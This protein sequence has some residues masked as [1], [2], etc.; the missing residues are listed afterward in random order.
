MCLP[1]GLLEA[2]CVEKQVLSRFSWIGKKDI[3]LLI[4]QK[5]IYNGGKW[6]VNNISSFLNSV[7]CDCGTIVDIGCAICVNI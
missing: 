6:R 3:P 5:N 2:G 4:W 7:L 1:S